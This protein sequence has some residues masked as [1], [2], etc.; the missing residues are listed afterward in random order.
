MR[1][2]LTG[3]ASK[4]SAWDIRGTATAAMTT[5]AHISRAT[6]SLEAEGW[7]LITF[8][9]SAAVVPRPTTKPITQRDL[10]VCHIRAR[11]S[12]P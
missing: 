6:S 12:W 11:S 8:R 1:M 4:A 7:P 2:A 10:R 3:L 5:V 9:P